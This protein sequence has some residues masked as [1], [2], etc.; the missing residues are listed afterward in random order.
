MHRKNLLFVAGL[1]IDIS[2]DL[3]EDFPLTQFVPWAAFLQRSDGTQEIFEQDELLE[4]LG[5]ESSS[6]STQLNL[7]DAVQAMASKRE[8]QVRL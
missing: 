6:N 2:P 7:E 5:A 8:V 4:R 3:G 1:N